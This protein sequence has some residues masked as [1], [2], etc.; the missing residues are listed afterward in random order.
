MEWVN[1]L[2]HSY[3]ERN[4][5]CL[6]NAANTL[7]INDVNTLYSLRVA[8]DNKNEFKNLQYFKETGGGLVKFQFKFGYVEEQLFAAVSVSFY[9]NGPFMVDV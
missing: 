8:K 3:W 9:K 7:N 5:T 2:T 4:M 6:A 1:L